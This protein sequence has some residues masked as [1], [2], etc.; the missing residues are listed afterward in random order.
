MQRDHLGFAVFVLCASLAP[1]G[2]VAS[3]QVR[4]VGA[5]SGTVTDSSDA[6]VPNARI[7]LR[8]SGTGN[9]KETTSNAE[10]NFSFPDLSFGS[11]EVT[12]SAPGFQNTVVPRVAVEASKTTDLA[13]HLPDAELAGPPPDVRLLSNHQAR[14]LR[15]AVPAVDGYVEHPASVGSR[16]A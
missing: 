1:G 3:A 8:D 11:F 5:I 14:L 6:A 4:I 16:P 10:G 2:R 7:V 9:L 12:V 13:I 15:Y